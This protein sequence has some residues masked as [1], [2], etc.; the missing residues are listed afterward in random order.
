[1]EA[2]ETESANLVPISGCAQKFLTRLVKNMQIVKK[3]V[4]EDPVFGELGSQLSPFPRF[5]SSYGLRY[6]REFLPKACDATTGSNY[7]RRRQR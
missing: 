3:P 7:N 2:K 5:V 6:S 4:T 1:M